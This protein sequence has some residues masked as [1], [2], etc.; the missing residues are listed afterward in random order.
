MAEKK[1][2]PPKL[3]TD[4][5]YDDWLRLVRWWK[6]QT[7]LSPERQGAALAASLEGKAL[8][9][10]FELDDDVIKSA[11]GVDK[12]IE[13]L[14]V[15]FK[16]NTLTQKIEDI[17]KFENLTRAENRSI[18]E[19]IAEFDKNINRLRKHRIDYPDDIKGFKLMKGAKL[20]PSEE[21]LIRATITDI[22]YDHVLKKLKDIYGDDKP[23]VSFNIKA[24]NTFYTETP[25][26]EEIEEDYQ[27]DDEEYNDIYYASRQRRPSNYQS[28][29]Y[30]HQN[31]RP[32]QN[33]N[34]G[35]PQGA[36]SSN[37]RNSKPGSPPIHPQTR[38]KGK[39]PV[40]RSGDQTRCRVCQSI[41][42][43]ERDCPDKANDVNLAVN[44]IVL[45][46]SNAVVLKTL[47][48]ET[49]SAAVLDSGA[50]ET[51][52]G[53]TWFE[54]YE[55][56]LNKKDSSD[57]VFKPSSK[58]F[59]FGDGKVVRSTKCAT[60]PAYI[61][62]KRVSINA[63][64]VEA[65]IPLLLSKT[66]M[67]NAKMQLNFETD[68]LAAFEQEIPLKVTAN[69]LYSLPITKTT[70]LIQEDA[71]EPVNPIVLKVVNARTDVEIATKLH[72]CFAHP[73]AD[74]L[75]RLVN[76]A[77]EQWSNND[78]LK[79]K[80]KEVTD[81]CSVCQVFKKPPPR[82]TVGLPQAREFQEAVAMDLKEYNGRQILHLVDLC[83]RLSAATFI[84]NKRKETIVKAILQIWSA[85]YGSPQKFRADNG[86][87]FANAEF[88]SFCEQF[89]ITIQST[90]AESPWSN[91]VVERHNQTIAR[92]MD[93]IINDTGCNAD[94]ALL[95]ALNAKNSLQNVAGFSPFQLVL[96]KN[97]QL[98]STLTD[99]LPAL[100][101]Q[102]N[103]SD[104][105]R[106][107]LNVIHA[108]REAFIAC[109]ND[110]K[111]RRALNS[112]V[113]TTGETKYVTGDTV[114][115]KRD[116]SIQWHGPAHVIGQVDQQ[117]FVKHGS[118]YVRVH[119]CR[120]QLVKGATRT[121]T[122]L[123]SGHITTSSSEAGAP[124]G[125]VMPPDQTQADCQQGDLEQNL[126]EALRIA[127][128]DDLDVRRGDPSSST[129]HPSE[130]S[131]QIAQ[132]PAIAQPKVQVGTKIRYKD[133]EDHPSQEAIIASRAGKATGVN[134][135]WWNTTRPDGTRHAVNLDQV[136]E[137]DIINDTDTTQDGHGLQTNPDAQETLVCDNLLATNKSRELE[138]KLAELDQWKTMG[139]YQEI[140]DNGQEC[141]SLRWVVKDKLSDEGVQVC[142]ARLCV[143][144][145]EEETNFRTDSPTCSRE[146]IRLFLSTTASRKWKIHSMD[147]KG[148]FLQGK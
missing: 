20:Q 140:E 94:L 114:L 32:T 34:P 44:E 4:R 11:D 47:V 72:R 80:I 45:H 100:T 12:I 133:Y 71:N 43:W 84:P 87:E 78:N 132:S 107:N 138:A 62:N 97:P 124:M 36:A 8:D 141:L 31:H 79:Q 46:A 145:F 38:A 77:G 96:G 126:E 26:D 49:W 55:S 92:S 85:V 28:R 99:D 108:A 63:D 129:P 91:G 30:R 56:S 29:P 119:P 137:W 81:S 74:R 117:V 7:D 139:V 144:G 60:I 19:Y 51:V 110:E 54:E 106:E 135:N 127:T 53:S 16:K 42:H 37:W 86:G 89:G 143:R 2:A 134:R 136:Y 21:K 50:T 59:R 1:P 146:G 10:V 14:D 109:E 98:P 70:Q 61:G 131:P 9:V 40:T 3:T 142:K 17:E 75:L 82:P 120:L 64:I 22:T 23:S 95:W 67:K 35:R 6:I 118:F 83:T 76:N 148:A 147:V 123:T 111:I 65:D 48:S 33:Y 116:P 125:A 69:G 113:R 58:G 18:K 25:S 41:N 93:K 122:E 112:N 5:S 52:C 57:I 13:K 104:L 15:L 24:E 88:I 105:M 102:S 103:M 130:A 39:N 121:V 66:A 68:S 101:A 115:Y 73:S 90:P 27:L 128:P